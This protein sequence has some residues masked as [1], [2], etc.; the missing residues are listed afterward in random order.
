MSKDITQNIFHKPVYRYP[1]SPATLLADKSKLLSYIHNTT[2]TNKVMTNILKTTNMLDT[3]I[4][5]VY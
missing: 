5:Y 3:K 4:N 2:T 1:Y